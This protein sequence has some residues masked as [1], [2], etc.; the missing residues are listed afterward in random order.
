MP[1]GRRFLE[2]YSDMTILEKAFKKENYVE[3]SFSFNSVGHP[4]I[5]FTINDTTAIFLL[6]TG[7]A[8]NVLDIEFAQR[9]G[10]PLIS[11]GEKGGGA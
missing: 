6:D 1:T 4:I 2:N 11:T 10:M 7:A 5:P 9:L 3:I 8:C